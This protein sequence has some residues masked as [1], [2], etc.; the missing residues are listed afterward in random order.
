MEIR[1]Q[2][3]YHEKTISTSRLAIL[4]GALL[5]IAFGVLD[6][7][8]APESYPV[9]WIIRFGIVAPTLALLLGLSFSQRLM[10]GAQ[11]IITMAVL[12]STVGITVMGAV[13]RPN[14]AAFSTYY[15]GV[16]LALMAGYTFVR[17][18]FWYATLVGLITLVVYQF[19]A[20][21]YQGIMIVPMG[22][23]IFF[24]N[25]FFLISANLIGMFACYFMER[26]ARLDYPA[27][28][29]RR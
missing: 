2:E 27:V 22:R 21:G 12:A 1:F 25:N 19:M 20:L 13:T 26:Y 14:E 17:L 9:I 5:I 3:D 16:L 23:E 28:S 15:V 10:R 24:N 18:R 11:W 29:D 4:L 8:T 6:K 7:V